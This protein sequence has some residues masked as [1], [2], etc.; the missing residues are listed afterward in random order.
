MAL[1]SEYSAIRISDGAKKREK[2]S[3]TLRIL[4]KSLFEDLREIFS[5]RVG[6]LLPS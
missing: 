6:N 3:D 1:D 5:Y 2:P 4:D